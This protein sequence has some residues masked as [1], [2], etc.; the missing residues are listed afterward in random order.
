MIFD[1]WLPPCSRYV[2]LLYIIKVCIH[3]SFTPLLDSTL[4][5]CCWLKIKGTGSFKCVRSTDHSCFSALVF[6]SLSQVGAS[7]GEVDVVCLCEA[8]PCTLYA[9]AHTPT[10]VSAQASYLSVCGRGSTCSDHRVF[11]QL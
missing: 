7:C 3:Q 8:G 1:K 2:I 4:L 9:E 5:R 10:P 11:L 6:V